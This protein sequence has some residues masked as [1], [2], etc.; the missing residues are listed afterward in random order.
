MA[1]AKARKQRMVSMDRERTK[2]PPINNFKDTGIKTETMLTKAQ[3]QIDEEFQTVQTDL[4]P[5]LQ[6]ACG[7]AVHRRDQSKSR[8]G[9]SKHRGEVRRT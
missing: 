5:F 3:D 4:H 6:A 8:G 1:A 2:L 9:D 7:I